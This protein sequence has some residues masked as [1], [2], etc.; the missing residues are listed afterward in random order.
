MKK[1][2][3]TNK[4]LIALEHVEAT[5]LRVRA[6]LADE[7]SVLYTM[8]R[9]L[10]KEGLGLRYIVRTHYRGTRPRGYWGETTGS[11]RKTAAYGAVLEIRAVGETVE[12][13]PWGPYTPT[14][15]IGYY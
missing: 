2:D 6:D 4:K 14:Y 12:N 13:Q 8:V 11:T 7:N 9:R 5:R 10:D 3:T 1:V 15:H